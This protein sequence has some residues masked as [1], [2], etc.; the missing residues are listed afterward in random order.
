MPIFIDIEN[1]F[2]WKR[3][4]ICNKRF[5][6]KQI[7]DKNTVSL[8][9]QESKT[10][11]NGGKSL[12]G[13]V[14]AFMIFFKEFPKNTSKKKR[15]DFQFCNK[16]PDADNLAKFLMDTAEKQAGIFENDSRISF[17]LVTKFWGNYDRTI[18]IFSEFTSYQQLILSGDLLGFSQCHFDFSTKTIRDI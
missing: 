11:H 2:A 10:K 3:T 6:D 1:I 9:M 16:K 17:L 4:G 7:D 8:F 12:V 13:N 14:G 18:A 5:F 15:S